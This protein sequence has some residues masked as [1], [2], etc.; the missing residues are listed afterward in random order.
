MRTLKLITLLAVATVVP[1]A[2][3]TVS[4]T[5]TATATVL[6]Q[7]T[8]TKTAD[9]TFPGSFASA[10]TVYP[11]SPAKFDGS[12]D[13]GNSLSVSIS[14]PSVLTRSGG[15]TIPFSCGTTSGL[16]QGAGGDQPFNPNTALAT[17]GPVNGTGAITVW[18]SSPFASVASDKCSVVLTGA[19]KGV[20]TGTITTTVTVL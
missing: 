14:L 6:A 19:L 13:V 5:A 17:T 20:Y 4:P 10:G 12:T 11:S 3:Q 2:A 9:M 15:A 7:L 1:A 16:F 18:V 8:L